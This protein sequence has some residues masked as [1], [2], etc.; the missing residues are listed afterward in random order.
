MAWKSELEVEVEVEVKA[1]PDKF[2][3]AIRNSN[4]LFPKVFPQQYKSIEI[5]EGDGK[6]VGS[7]RLV[8]YAKGIYRYNTIYVHN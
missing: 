3:G 4:E 2:W 7:V 5:L 6:T 8:R 1:T